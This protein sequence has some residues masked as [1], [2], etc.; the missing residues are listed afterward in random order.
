MRSF[1]RPRTRRRAAGA[2][3]SLALVALASAGCSGQGA[4]AQP[5]AAADASKPGAA[6]AP[7]ASSGV[8]FGGDAQLTGLPDLG[9]SPA[10]VRTYDTLDNAKAFP[11]AEETRA[12]SAGATLLASLGTG[13]DRDWA[14]VA[15][16]K[17]DTAALGFLRAVDS[18][19]TTHHLKT[20]YVSFSHEPNAKENERKG[21]PAQFVAAWRHMRRL[22]TDARLDARNGG[23]L[24]WV[25]ILTANGFHQSGTPERY[26]P[27]AENVDVVGVD[28]YVSGGCSKQASGNYVNPSKTAPKPGTVFDSALTWSAA[29]APG[30]PVF[31]PEWGSVPFTGSDVRASYV[32]AMTGY[33]AAHQQIGAV[34]YWNDHAHHDSCDYSLG[35]DPAAQRAL[36]AMGRDAHFQ[37]HP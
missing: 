3:A 11:S 13:R 25:W 27:G 12:L 6:P 32:R 36:A 28:G 1:R 2:A 17:S 22:A 16:G 37:A 24:S 33:V 9:R 20:V 23:H 5:G 8:L 35:G 15:A 34:L 29:H 19:A 26:W 18:A 31:V 14:S 7:A 30:K 4:A 10:I 21:S